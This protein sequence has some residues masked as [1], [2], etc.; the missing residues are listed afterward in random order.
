MGKNCARGLEYEID[1][2]STVRETQDEAPLQ[3][4]AK[5][6]QTNSHNF[7]TLN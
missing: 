5:N 7:K 1:S 6:N 2:N 4:Q 3:R